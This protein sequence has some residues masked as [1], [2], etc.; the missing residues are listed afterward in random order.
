MIPIRRIAPILFILPLIALGACDDGE[1]TAPE[2]PVEY[3]V[4][5]SGDEF[6]VRVTTRAQ[7]D[8][9]EAR[10][11]SGAEGVIN[12]A[13]EA[14]DGGFNTSWSWHMVPASVEAVDVSI[15]VCDG[16]PS[17]VEENLDY[18]LDTVGRFCPW[19]AVVTGRL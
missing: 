2:P 9:M 18:W 13:L 17:M 11:S 8:D 4:E 12:G 5:V 14:G 7:V 3:R 16:R 15:E 6:V 10:L 19:N 1:P